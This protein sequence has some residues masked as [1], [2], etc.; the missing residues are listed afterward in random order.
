MENQEQEQHK[1]LW[2]NIKDLGELLAETELWKT[3][4]WLYESLGCDCPRL[5]KVAKRLSFD[6]NIKA[7]LLKIGKTISEIDWDGKKTD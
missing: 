3:F 5:S 1:E 7:T 2:K 4:D 6:D